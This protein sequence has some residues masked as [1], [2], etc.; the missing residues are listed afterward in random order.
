MPVAVTALPE[1]V[2][3]ILRDLSAFFRD[4]ECLLQRL[5]DFAARRSACAPSITE[6]PVC[7]Y[8]VYVERLSNLC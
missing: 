7:K 8:N 2:A 3:V 1:H 4:A 5:R 6:G